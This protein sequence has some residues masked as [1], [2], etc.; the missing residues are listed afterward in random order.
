MV[1][2]STQGFPYE[3]S[4]HMVTWSLYIIKKNIAIYILDWTFILSWA[5][6]RYPPTWNFLSRKNNCMCNQ[7]NARDIAACPDE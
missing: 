7:D 1:S 3:S 4:S 6:T 2:D 5:T